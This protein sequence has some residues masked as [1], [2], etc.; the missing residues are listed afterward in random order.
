M[1]TPVDAY[2][3][4]PTP[5]WTTHIASLACFFYVGT[6]GA[7]Q[8]R[9]RGTVVFEQLRMLVPKG[10][11]ITEQDRINGIVDRRGTSIYAGA[12]NIES[13]T[14]AHSHLELRLESAG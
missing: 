10:T 5:S 11:D 14:P 12:L 8:A 3:D 4:A 9:Q 1:V 7:E 13:V 6:G 2:G